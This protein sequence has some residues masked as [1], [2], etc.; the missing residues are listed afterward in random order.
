[1]PAAL[2]RKNLGAVEAVDPRR[3]A[4]PITRI[5]HALLDGWR[6]RSRLGDA[7]V[8][9]GGEGLVADAA[10]ARRLRV[11][12]IAGLVSRH[13]TLV[14]VSLAL[15]LSIPSVFHSH[16][17]GDDRIHLGTV[18]GIF[19]RFGSAPFG[20]YG[21]VDGSAE[22]V[23][24]QMETGPLPWNAHPNMKVN[25]FR[26]VSSGLLALDHALFKRRS[27]GYRI[28]SLLWY[29]LLIAVFARW[30]PRVL[31]GGTGRRAEQGGGSGHAP[32]PGYAA[33]AGHRADAGHAAVVLGLLVFAVS[34]SHWI[35]VSW[36]APRWVLVSTTLA[37][38]GCL[39]HMR[40]RMDGWKWGRW[41][42]L[43][44]L[45]LALLAG[46]SALAVLSYLFAYE[47]VGGGRAIR[48]RLRALAPHAVLV[49]AYLLAYRHLG[50][51]ASGVGSYLDPMTDPA[52]YLA[53]LPGR[54]LAMCGELFLWYPAISW[55]TDSL[56]SALAGGA[57]IILMALLIAPVFRGGTE[58][59]RRVIARLALGTAGA[60]LPLA[61]GTPGSR[62][63]VI[64]FLGVAALVGLALHH[65]WSVARR[66]VGLV[67][68]GAAP[69]CLGLVLVH[70][71]IAPAA[72]IGGPGKVHRAS[73]RLVALAT[74]APF[75]DVD[76]PGQRTLF[77]TSNINSSWDSYFIRKFMRLPMP[78]RWW[79]LS[80]AAGRHRYRRTAAGRLELEI[81]RAK[82]ASRLGGGIP[83]PPHPM[84]VGY[85]VRLDGL[86]VKVLEMDREKRHTRVE[87]T[88]D[89]PLDDPSIAL[90]AILDGRPQRVEPP[91]PGE[92][93]TLPSPW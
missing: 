67:R 82:A 92:T 45:A 59:M 19:E 16:F 93:L 12:A 54:I 5:D 76:V 36:T 31:S 15:L 57:G 29:L 44:A 79:V 73:D 52:G 40:W 56:T 22:R 55:Y 47:I 91:A 42:S 21:F 49:L 75:V 20:L 89:R 68:R 90:I 17:L 64:P 80:D 53:Q 66:G 41:L 35:N 61:A 78:E 85:E 23:F 37:L 3:F 14:A 10:P 72:W 11:A 48:D 84:R 65:W 81:D 71:V 33:D 70:L 43:F 7:P 83:G 24:R 1:V 38:T 8:V 60:L 6:R 4:S 18:E 46:E 74:E 88:L 34:D 50:Y 28:Q 32:H 77:L 69:I 51:G 30:L 9:R 62:N 86:R 58:G 26:P 2:Y 63:L 25:F 27:R 39:A 13:A 87:F